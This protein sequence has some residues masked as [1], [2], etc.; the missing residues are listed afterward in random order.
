MKYYALACVFFLVAYL[1]P[2]AGRPMV[3]P[4]E[5]RYAE[6]PREMIDSGDYVSPR[7]VGMRYFEKPVL[8]YWMTAGCFRL[9]GENAFAL[10]LPS[11][12]GAGLAALLAALLV[13]QT[14]HDEKIAVLAAVLYLTF[15]M[16]YGIGTFAV[17]DSQLTGFVTGTSC[18]A[19]LAALEPRFTRR[20]AALLGLCGVFASCAFLTKGFLAFAVPALAMTGFLLWERRWK[21][22]LILP[23]IPLAVALVIIAPWALAVYR[24]D[25]DYWHYFVL[26]EH[27]QRFLSGSGEHHPEPYWFL[28]PF[29]LGGLFPAGVL[30]SAAIPGIHGERKNFFRS[31]LNRFCLCA[32]GLPFL[33]FSISSGKLPTYILPC[34]PF[35]AVLG[36]EG[37]AAYFRTGGTHRTFDVVMSVWGG[38]LLLAGLGVLALAIGNLIPPLSSRRFVFA[39]LGFC[40]LLSGSLLLFSRHT[41]WRTRFYLFFFGIGLIVLV[42]GWVASPELLRSK[43]PESALRAF[44]EQLG[45]APDRAVFITYPSMIHAVAWVYHRP[46]VL[47]Y[48]SEGELAYGIR[49]AQQR[50]ER[51][52]RI[53]REELAELLLNPDRPDVVFI[54]RNNGKPDF[55]VK[56]ESRSAVVNDVQAICFP[57]SGSGQAVLGET[58]R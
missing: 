50:K 46:D 18:T 34:F 16:S 26:V 2:L 1:L 55:P 32:V 3:V 11:A 30:L 37:V 10:R 19:F 39:L 8:G 21:D 52:A 43:A 35:L 45:F 22:F 36:S 51:S 57:A 12:L 24:A 54:A 53:N 41:L 29:L 23:W 48:E 44:P 7:L 25:S 31:P 49:R 38:L 40:G 58:R 6:I 14:L 56:L 33:F 47:L 17:L 15:G 5:F 28:I 9:F 42:G 27:L 13:Q 4:D 20:K